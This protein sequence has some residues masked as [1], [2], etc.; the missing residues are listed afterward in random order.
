MVTRRHEVRDIA[1]D[2]RPRHAH[3]FLQMTGLLIKLI[4]PAQFIGHRL[5]TRD[6]RRCATQ[7]GKKSGQIVMSRRTG[8]RWI[9]I[10]VDHTPV[11]IPVSGAAAYRRERFAERTVVDHAAVDERNGDRID[12][13][14]LIWLEVAPDEFP[15]PRPAHAPL[16]QEDIHLADL[17]GRKRTRE[18]GCGARRESQFRR[19]GQREITIG[20]QPA[21]A[22]TAEVQHMA[23]FALVDCR[24]IVDLHQFLIAVIV[25]QSDVEIERLMRRQQG[26][27]GMTRLAHGRDGV[28]HQCQ[29]PAAVQR[30]LKPARTQEQRQL[31][32]NFQIA[33]FRQT[34]CMGKPQERP[35]KPLAPATG[36]GLGCKQLSDIAVVQPQVAQTAH[37]Q[38]VTER[39]RQHGGVDA[40]G[41]G[42]GDDIH[43]DPQVHSSTDI[44][45]QLE[46]HRLGVEAGSVAIGNVGIAQRLGPV[47]VADRMQRGRGAHKLKDFR[48]DAV[49][50][51][52]QRDAAKA[53]E[54][55][56]QLFLLQRRSR[57][58]CAVHAD[59]QYRSLVIRL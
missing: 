2:L 40:T 31:A 6:I 43:D 22:P 39:A 35:Q 45:Q 11:H 14:L 1:I 20:Q 7:R 32:T 58:R 9:R 16:S 13:G 34:Q 33:E 52:S 12:I 55:Y 28:V 4:D 26:R 30:W 49:D 53:H 15:A 21:I 36:A 41:G 48:S 17:R 51:N 59:D 19:I 8:Q 42:A 44:P 50:I 46:V 47:T 3:D 37:R 54:C 5:G 56:A 57:V 38:I 18:R 24:W 27:G 23:V 29:H 25:R 10:N